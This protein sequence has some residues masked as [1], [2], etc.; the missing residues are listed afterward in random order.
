MKQFIFNMLAGEN[1]SI[2]HKRVIATIGALCLFGTFVFKANINEHLAD[3]I[4]W[5]VCTC[6]GFASIDKWTNK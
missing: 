6:M 1:G 5:L 4:F 2:S 3:L